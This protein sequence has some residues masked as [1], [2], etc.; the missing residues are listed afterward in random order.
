MIPK[1]QQIKKDLLEEIRNHVFVPGDKFYSEADIKKRYSVSSITAVK[2]L[3]ELTAMGYLYRIQGKGTFVSKAKI[4]Q[5]VRFSD[6]ENHSIDT[7]ETRVLS[8]T[9]ENHSEIL[10]KLKLAKTDSYYKIVRVRSS[11]GVPFILTMTHLPK[12][13]MKEPISQNLDDYISIYDRVRNDFGVDLFTQASVETN[14]IVF[15]D[16]S[17]ITNELRLSFREPAV[18]QEKCTYLTDNSVAEYIVSYKHWKAFKTKI[19]VEAE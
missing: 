18:L 13:L 15:P 1:Y 9:Q 11:E 2:A 5:T 17:F 6:I 4:S 16:D 14:E 3:N 8:V 19:E 7:E 12:K 10:K